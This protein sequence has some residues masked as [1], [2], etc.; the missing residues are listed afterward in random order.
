MNSSSKKPPSSLD[1]NT[2]NERN[3]NGS[4]NSA[5][6]VGRVNRFTN[7]GSMGVRGALDNSFKS[8]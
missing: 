2:L 3:K 8:P 4:F 1:R 7:L 5:S 6:A